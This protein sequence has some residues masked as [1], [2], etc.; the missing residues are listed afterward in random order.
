MSMEFGAVFLQLCS[1]N[2]WPNVLAL[3]TAWEFDSEAFMMKMHLRLFS[4]T[5]CLVLGYRS[6][7]S[8]NDMA[9][10]ASN[11]SFIPQILLIRS[12]Y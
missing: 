8:F 1:S 7:L 4:T 6:K 10:S 3:F 5:I 2:L 9:D 11:P 12:D